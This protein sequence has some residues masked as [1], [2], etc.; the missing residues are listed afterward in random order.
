MSLWRDDLLANERTAMKG[1]ST[2]T[3]LALVIAEAILLTWH[4]LD[5]WRQGGI[6]AA[7]QRLRAEVA[8]PGAKFT[9]EQ[10]TGDQTNGQTCGR[11]ETS[12]GTS[13]RFIV[14]IDGREPLI[15]GG[16]SRKV[17][18]QAEFEEAWQS[19]CLRQGYNVVLAR[20]EAWFGA[21]GAESTGR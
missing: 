20:G 19:D 5:A 6:V 10:L 17:L 1:W 7:E 8:D 4:G 9:E 18:S 15:D 3:V 16:L 21:G 14:Y 12:S 13:E 2:V 11:V